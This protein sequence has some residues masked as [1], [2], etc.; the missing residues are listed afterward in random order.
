MVTIL[1]NS[2]SDKKIVNAMVD[3]WTSIWERY[4]L[5]VDSAVL[6]YYQKLFADQVATN[7]GW[8]A[9][10]YGLQWLLHKV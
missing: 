2:Y 4:E 6:N 3:K 1:Q 5:V 10:K 7:G 8:W 9:Y